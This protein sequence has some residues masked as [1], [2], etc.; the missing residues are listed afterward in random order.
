MATDCS[1][2]VVAGLV[3]ATPQKIEDCFTSMRSDLLRIITPWEQSG[4][5]E[6]GLDQQEEDDAAPSNHDDDPWANVNNDES[7]ML[8]TSASTISST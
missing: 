3:P 2:E 5:G 7:M 6:G 8:R 1:S 4:Q